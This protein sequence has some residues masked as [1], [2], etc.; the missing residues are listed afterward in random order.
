MAVIACSFFLPFINNTQ[1]F[2]IQLLIFKCMYI[3]YYSVL[4]PIPSLPSQHHSHASS[5]C[6]SQML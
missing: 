4:R 5:Y 1:T 2:A 6:R 3:L